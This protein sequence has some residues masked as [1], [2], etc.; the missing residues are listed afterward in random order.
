[1]TSLTGELAQFSINE[2][3]QLVRSVCIAV[4]NGIEEAGHIVHVAR[5]SAEL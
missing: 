4:L 3:K 5:Q 2:W 1:M